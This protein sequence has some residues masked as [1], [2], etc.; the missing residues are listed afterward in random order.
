MAVLGMRVT[1]YLLC[2]IN[3]A[4]STRKARGC[5]RIIKYRSVF[6]LLDF[7]CFRVCARPPP[8]HVK[9]T[10]YRLRIRI[11]ASARGLA[12]IYGDRYSLSASRVL[13][14]ANYSPL[15]PPAPAIRIKGTWP[16]FFLAPLPSAVMLELYPPSITR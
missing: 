10:G 12:K 8:R 15:P 5:A 3:T 6:S 7:S 16:S 13:P 1:R 14:R 4:T 11:G 9:V 2:E